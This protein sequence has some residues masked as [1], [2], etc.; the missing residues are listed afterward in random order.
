M[1]AGHVYVLA[2]D[3]GT[4]K[5]GQTQNATQRLNSHKSIA[6]G[7]GHT[8]TGEWVSPLHAG[9]RA[10]EDALKAIAAELGG[11]PAGQEYFSGVDFTMVV[12]RAQR[13]TFEAPEAATS[14][15]EPDAEDLPRPA[16]NPPQRSD[17]AIAI[18]DAATEWVARMIANEVA[19]ARLFLDKGQGPDA[20]DGIPTAS[21]LAGIMR[22]I[23]REENEIRRQYDTVL[24]IQRRLNGPVN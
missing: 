24:T 7:F 17:R 9:W 8:V 4:V 10:N 14:P 21:R 11:T 23:L 13:L 20:I 3:N 15:P 22:L 6:R 19:G 2:F 12:D 18:R 1:N 16:E 5:V